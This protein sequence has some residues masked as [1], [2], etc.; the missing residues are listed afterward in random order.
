ME[1]LGISINSNLSRP[2]F[3]LASSFGLRPTA[4]GKRESKR[5]ADSDG[6]GAQ[7]AKKTKR[8]KP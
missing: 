8:E 6:G 2:A 3:P 7:K 1:I 5:G 4:G